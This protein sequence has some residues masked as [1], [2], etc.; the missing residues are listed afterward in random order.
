[1]MMT[2]HPS[3]MLELPSRKPLHF[4]HPL[5]V[6]WPREMLSELQGGRESL[7]VG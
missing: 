5:I 3:L 6:S 2:P 1:M 4:S 7:G